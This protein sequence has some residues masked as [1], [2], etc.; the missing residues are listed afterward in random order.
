MKRKQW[1]SVPLP[2][3]GQKKGFVRYFSEAVKEYPSNVTYVDLFGG[4][5]LLSHTVKCVHPNAKVI[6]ND[7]DNFR[8]RLEAIPQTNKILDELRALNL[9]TPRNKRIKVSNRML[10]AK[11][12]KELTNEVL[13]VG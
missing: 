9:Q 7:Y 4:S 10:S 13:W 1:K 6:Y 3:Q 5:G 2:F 12:L 11:Y 8:Q